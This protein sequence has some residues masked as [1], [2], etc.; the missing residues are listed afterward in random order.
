MG[1]R[2]AVAVH[3][4]KLDIRGVSASVGGKQVLKNVS[5]AIAPGEIHAL[6]GPNGSGKSSLSA[7][8]AGNP[9][10]VVESGEIVCDNENILGLSP[11]ERARKGIFLAFQNPIEIPGVT[12][13]KFL[14]TIAK[15]AN[16]KLSF[17]A[18]KKTLD[19]ALA[20]LNLDKSFV[21]RDL[22]VG[23]S[24]GEKKRAEI[25]QLLILKP[26]LVILD[27]MDSGLDVDSLQLLSQAVNALKGPN[28]SMLVIT[29]YQRLLNYIHPDVVHILANGELV[30]TANAELAKKVE[31]EGYSWLKFA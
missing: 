18:F 20:T 16:P 8:I 6:M 11:D 28:F 23:F 12:L 10:Y 22:N 7:I 14:F 21:E 26:K 31:A 30:A 25:L 17:V 2:Q 1:K 24:G 13:S 9:K 27:E 3:V 4:M 29:H 15:I 5:L 19:E